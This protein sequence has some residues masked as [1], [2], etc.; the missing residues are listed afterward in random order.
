MKVVAGTGLGIKNATD[1]TIEI[2]SLFMVSRDLVTTRY[3]MFSYTLFF[4]H[5]L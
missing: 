4:D 2:E 3:C 5:Q 1:F